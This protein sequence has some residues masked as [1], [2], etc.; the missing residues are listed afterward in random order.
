MA[1][2]RACSMPPA[3]LR[4]AAPQAILVKC[5]L[6]KSKNPG[7]SIT[8]P[9]RC[10]LNAHAVRRVARGVPAGGAEQ[11]E[12]ARVPHQVRNPHHETQLT[13]RYS[14]DAMVSTWFKSS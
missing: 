8:L 7:A 2:A 14:W 12:L 10:S 1:R 5:N 13:R 4:D 11:G 6:Y 9:P 3:G